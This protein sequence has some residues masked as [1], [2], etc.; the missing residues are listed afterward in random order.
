MVMAL[1]ETISGVQKKAT[2]LT[3]FRLSFESWFT[4]VNNKNGVTLVADHTLLT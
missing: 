2:K 3:D 1:T 4:W